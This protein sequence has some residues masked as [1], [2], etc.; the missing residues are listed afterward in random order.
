[1]AGVVRRPREGGPG[2]RRRRLLPPRR[3]RPPQLPRP[4]THGRPR[5]GGALPRPDPGR[6]RPPRQRDSAGGLGF[7]GFG[8][9]RDGREPGA[10]RVVRQVHGDGRHCGLPVA[11]RG[12]L[13]R[14]FPCGRRTSAASGRYRRH[15]RTRWE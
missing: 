2:V 14:G 3:R 15:Q 12:L 6:R 7:G 5:R 10:R 13:V 4:A 1:M 8:R 9:D 11:L